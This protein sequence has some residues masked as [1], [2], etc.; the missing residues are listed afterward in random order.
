MLWGMG[1]AWKAWPG[2]DG[3]TARRLG[4]PWHQGGQRAYVW[5]GGGW[6]LCEASEVTGSGDSAPEAQ[7]WQSE[8]GTC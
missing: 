2:E 5:L 1:G 3:A 7:V 4:P 8:Q 6:G